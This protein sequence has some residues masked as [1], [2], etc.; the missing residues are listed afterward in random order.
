M[1]KILI[2]TKDNPNIIYSFFILY[3]FNLFTTLKRIIN[4][5]QCH[6]SIKLKSNYD[7]ILWSWTY[8]IYQNIT[9]LIKMIEKVT[10]SKLIQEAYSLKYLSLW[11]ELNFQAINTSNSYIFRE[12]AI[13]NIASALNFRFFSFIVEWFQFNIDING[14]RH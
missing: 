13:S 3:S 14:Y 8:K 12:K 2:S 11:T 4:L 5:I 9:F 10:Y 6:Q 1:N 7:K